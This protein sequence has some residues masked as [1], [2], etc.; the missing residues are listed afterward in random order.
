MLGAAGIAIASTGRERHEAIYPVQRIPLEFSH[1]LHV[2]QVTADGGPGIAAP[3][4]TCHEVALKSQKA[5]DV[6]VPK[7][8][9]RSD[10][11]GPW[12]P[13]HEVCET[14]H[15]IEHAMEGKRSADDAPARCENCHRGY[16]P[17]ASNDPKRRNVVQ[18]TSFPTANLVFNHKIHFDKLGKAVTCETCHFGAD[19]VGMEEV[20]LSTR[21]QLP[22]M[23]LCLGCHNGATAPADCRTCHI[24]EPSGRIQVSFATAPLRPIQGDPLGLDHGPRYE[25][26]H[27][28]RAKVDRK[29]CSECHTD[30]YCATCH[31]SLQKPLSVHPN[32]FVTLHP[33]Q[34]K[35]DSTAC[36]SCHRFQSF[37]AA[38]HERVGIGMDSDP[39]LRARNLKVHGDYNEWVQSTTSPRHHAIAASRDLK[40]CMAC[41]RE[42]SCLTCHATSSVSPRGGTNPHADGFDKR[43]RALMQANDRACLKCHRIDELKAKDACR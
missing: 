11:K 21:Y 7:A 36:E 19:G 9:A 15:D 6:L 17:K 29:T 28:T 35:M 5:S 39:T 25:F 3:C 12:W 33:L 23:A 38:C 26:T 2:E 20:D 8:V 16:D 10:K 42:E 27:G 43:C 30:S 22:K 14:C 24:T 4:V 13:E 32:D 18:T 41:H 34:A 37:C 40:Q 1:G 31:D